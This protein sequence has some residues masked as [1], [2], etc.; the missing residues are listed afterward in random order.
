[1][2]MVFG[3]MDA[4]TTVLFQCL[5]NLKH[6]PADRP[7]N[8]MCAL[9]KGVLAVRACPFFFSGDIRVLEKSLSILDS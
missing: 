6:L 3:Q 4:I 5:L 1:M 7:K 9:A 2:L 8:G